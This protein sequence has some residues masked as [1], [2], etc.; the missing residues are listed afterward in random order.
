MANLIHIN[1]MRQMLKSGEP[2]SLK[3]W[4]Q[5]A[6]AIVSLDNAFG[7]SSHHRG[8]SFRFKLLTSGQWRKVRAITVFEINDLEV[9]I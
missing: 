5:E 2:V 4:R 1:V 3:F 7:P 6:G 9:F 8:N